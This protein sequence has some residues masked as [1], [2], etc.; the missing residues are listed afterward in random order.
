[1]ANGKQAALLGPECVEQAAAS[2]RVESTKEN[3]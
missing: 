2:E 1:M 3:R